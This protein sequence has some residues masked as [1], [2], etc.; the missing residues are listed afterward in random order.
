MTYATCLLE[1]LTFLPNHPG[2]GSVSHTSA[3]AVGSVKSPSGICSLLSSPLPLSGPVPS[4]FTWTQAPALS[5]LSLSSPRQPPGGAR[6]HL[7][8]VRPLPI[9]HRG[10]HFPLG[11]S[12][13]LSAPTQPCATRHRHSPALPLPPS[14]SHILLQ[15][16]GFFAGLPMAKH[17]PAP[18]PLPALS[19][20]RECP[21]SPLPSSL[22]RCRSSVSTLICKAPPRLPHSYV[23]RLSHFRFG[24]SCPPS[25]PGHDLLSYHVPY[26]CS[27]FLHRGTSPQELVSTFARPPRTHAAGAR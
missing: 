20:S 13:V 3:D 9:T 21:K 26:F 25:N 2:C 18:G 7:S 27:A 5:S 24:V 4:W 15:P 1:S 11:K 8:Q 23:P 12:Q 16:R 22:F 19:P 14:L 17:G 10:P 6:E